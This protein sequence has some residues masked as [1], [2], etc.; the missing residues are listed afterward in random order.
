M[1]E[2]SSATACCMRSL[3][4]LN[5]AL[6]LSMCDSRICMSFLV[7]VSRGPQHPLLAVRLRGPFAPSRSRLWQPIG[8]FDFRREQV[9]GVCFRLRVDEQRRGTAAA[10]ALMEKKI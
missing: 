1:R 7:S 3:F 4:A 2:R 6:F 5:V 9:L 8:N 10:E